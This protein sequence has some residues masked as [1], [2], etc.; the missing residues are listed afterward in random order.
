MPATPTGSTLKDSLLKF[1]RW[2]C[3]HIY[4]WIQSQWD[5]WYP[6]TW[7]RISAMT[8]PW[9]S[10]FH[11]RYLL[12]GWVLFLTSSVKPCWCEGVKLP[13]TR[14]LLTTGSVTRNIKDKTLKGL[15]KK[16]LSPHHDQIKS[17]NIWK[18]FRIKWEKNYWYLGKFFILKSAILRSSISRNFK[19]IFQRTCPVTW[20]LQ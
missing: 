16:C 14:K 2:K 19:R 12:F 3:L 11:F 15:I 20:F 6:W 8:F 5:L 18:S 9:G 7:Q 13:L 4:P 1:C 10:V 17:V